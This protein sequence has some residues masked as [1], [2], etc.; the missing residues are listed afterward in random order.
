MGQ[1][2]STSV[3][4]SIFRPFQLNFF[5]T[6]L[7]LFPY[8]FLYKTQTPFSLR[9]L[10]PFCTQYVF[11]SFFPYT[12]NYHTI[13]ESKTCSKRFLFHLMLSLVPPVAFLTLHSLS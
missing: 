9:S 8:K 10:D 13:S 5:S 7:L 6:K 3:L 4:P 12:Q 1:A 11:F 2:V